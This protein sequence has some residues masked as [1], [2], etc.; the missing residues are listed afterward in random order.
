MTSNLS[1]QLAVSKFDYCETEIDY[2]I[3]VGWPDEFRVKNVPDAHHVHG[4]PSSKRRRVAGRR[5]LERGPRTRRGK[6]GTL[7]HAMGCT[8]GGRRTGHGRRVRARVPGSM[9]YAHLEHLR[10]RFDN[11]ITKDG[12]LEKTKRIRFE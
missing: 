1:I 11:E 10:R 12:N 8:P 3:T 7:A 4:F 2:L 9:K 5:D 6:L